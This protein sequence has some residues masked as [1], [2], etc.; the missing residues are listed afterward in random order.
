MRRQLSKNQDHI[1]PVLRVPDLRKP[2]TVQIDASEKAI[3]AVLLQRH[4][5]ELLPCAY[6]SRRLLDR[7]TKY[8]IIEKECLAVVYAL[9]TFAK[10][11]VMKPFYILMDHQA[12]TFL[13]FNKSRNARLS[14]W[15]L[16]IQQYTFTIQHIRGADN[17][18]ADTLSRAY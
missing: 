11:L 2:F 14:R 18:I 9:H 4:D 8:A 12:L 3:A 17:I 7:E 1:D 6:I 13:K 5:S 10:F 15:A 16:S